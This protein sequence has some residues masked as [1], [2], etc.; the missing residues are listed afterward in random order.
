MTFPTTIWQ[1]NRLAT[2]TGTTNKPLDQI[3]YNLYA[4][5]AQTALG[6][7]LGWSYTNSVTR[8][9]A[10]PGTAALPARKYWYHGSGNTMQW[11]KAVCTYTG[12]NLTKVALYFSDNNE[13][14]Y[15]PMVDGDAGLNYVLT[16]TYSGADLTAASWGATP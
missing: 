2:P 8:G 6:V 9:E 10:S 13:A 7:S 14:T 5:V 12:T 15:V 1:P 4:M 16:L 11:V 3:R